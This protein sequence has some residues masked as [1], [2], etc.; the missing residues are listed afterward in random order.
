MNLEPDAPL[1][2]KEAAEI[3]LRGLVKEATLVAAADRG[4]L[5]TERIGK[6]RV[7]TPAYV[8]SWR[9]RCRDHERA[10]ICGSGQKSDILMGRSA[11]T[12]DGSSATVD[13]GLAQDAA[14]MTAMKLKSGSGN[15][16]LRST[17]RPAASVH[18]LKSRSE[19]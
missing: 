14:L 6:R 3:C 2:L 18:Y 13:V 1:S 8:R 4:E 11:Q 12:P 7:T 15:T 16:S 9:E 5:I 19:T 17:S 10:R